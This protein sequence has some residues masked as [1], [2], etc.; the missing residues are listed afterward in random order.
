MPRAYR[1][2]A[3]LA[4]AVL[5]TSLAVL[6][7]E[8]AY[9][10]FSDQYHLVADFKNAGQLLTPGSNVKYRGVNIGK[11]DSVHLVNRRV[12]VKLSIDRGF[13]VPADTS[14]TVRP[15]TLFGEKYID[16]AFPH[17]RTGPFLPANGHI[18]S[19]AAAE[20]VEGLFEGAVPLFA[21]INATDLATIINELSKGLDGEGANI[22]KSLNDGVRLADVFSD[23][24]DAQTRALDSFARFQD[25]IRTIGPDLNAISANS[26]LALPEFNQARADYTRVLATLKPFADNLADVLRVYR[27]DIDT[28]LTQGDNVVRVLLARQSDISDTVSGLYRY[29]LKFSKGA[30]PETLPGGSKFAYFKNFVDFSDVQNLICASLAPPQPGADFLKP[31]QQALLNSGGPLDCSA[32]F[33]QAASKAAPSAAQAG[34]NLAT[35]TQHVLSAPQVPAVDTVKALVDQ[36]LGKVQ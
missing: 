34:R 24:I 7:V 29:T 11:V 23:T 22:A 3:A 32:Y 4:L 19:T 25:A 20:E 30:S 5:L 31:L 2:A 18:T 35:Q 26:N 36:I 9:G 27:P 21:K 6:A 33:T 16:F 15:K 10:T 1:A 8:G 17:G 28:I 13:H 12:Q 14:A